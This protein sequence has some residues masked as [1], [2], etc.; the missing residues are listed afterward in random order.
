MGP[1]R[2]HL[3][4]H[5]GHQHLRGHRA[6]VTVGPVAL[7]HPHAREWCPE[8]WGRLALTSGDWRALRGGWDGDRKRFL[9]LLAELPLQTWPAHLEP[10]RESRVLALALCAPGC[11]MLSAATTQNPA[12]RPHSSRL[13]SGPAPSSH[14][15]SSLHPEGPSSLLLHLWALSALCSVQSWTA[16]TCLFLEAFPNPPAPGRFASSC[17]WLHIFPHLPP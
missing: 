11:R 10:R 17:F 7:P 13:A 15:G 12:L 3:L 14:T 5:G 6:A 9:C 2:G 1:C 8:K 16:L 4:L